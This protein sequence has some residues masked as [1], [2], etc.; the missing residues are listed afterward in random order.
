MNFSSFNTYPLG[1]YPSLGVAG[2]GAIS[3]SAEVTSQGWVTQYATA[4]IV[5]SGATV[6][7][8]GIVRYVSGAIAGSA[9]VVASGY[10]LASAIAEVTCSANVESSSDVLRYVSA[11]VLCH[12]TLGVNISEK[13]GGNVYCTASVSA[14]SYVTQSAAAAIE[15]SSTVSAS[16][17]VYSLKYGVA[18]VTSN[19]SVGASAIVYSLKYSIAEVVAN[20]TVGVSGYALRPTSGEVSCTGTLVGSASVGRYGLGSITS[21][22][23]FTN[24]LVLVNANTRAVDDRIL[25]VSTDDRI[26]IVNEEERLLLAA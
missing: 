10:T 26:L 7:I 25:V 13:A 15:G 14:S 6:S 17:T 5:C 21:T 3:C 24:N 1:G 23:K 19:A 8:G 20:S 18:E 9:N 4:D 22:A 2:E 16:A 11:S 12:A